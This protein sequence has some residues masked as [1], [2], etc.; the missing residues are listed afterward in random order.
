MSPYKTILTRERGTPGGVRGRV[1]EQP[2]GR[3]GREGR[4]SEARRRRRRILL[5]FQG[6]RMVNSI[7]ISFVIRG[8]RKGDGA[9]RPDGV[10]RVSRINRDLFRVTGLE[11]YVRSS[12]RKRSARLPHRER[13]SVRLCP[14]SPMWG[15]PAARS[16]YWGVA[17]EG[18]APF[19]AR[20]CDEPARLWPPFFPTAGVP[21]GAHI[22]REWALYLTSPPL[23][24]RLRLTS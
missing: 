11:K 10:L 19:V 5:N 2:A 23:L 22:V 13:L 3:G 9:G 1:F 8:R 14:R 21:Q 6:T 16:S 24:R 4:P 18:G 15:T 7:G 20:P 12:R 17:S